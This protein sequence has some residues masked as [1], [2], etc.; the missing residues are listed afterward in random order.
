MNPV[1]IWGNLLSYSVQ[2]LALVAAG[3]ILQ[4]L[5]RVRLPRA[6]LLFCQMMLLVCFLLPAVQPWQSPLIV[7]PEDTAA[8]AVS[9]A[10]QQPVQQQ[11]AQRPTIPWEKTALM[12]LA[13]G[14]ALRALWLLVGL[15]RLSRYRTSATPLYPLPEA[16]EAA[17]IR[18]GAEA[19]V[20]VSS[21]VEGP[22]TF[23]YL[24]PVILLPPA[25]LEKPFETQ[26][27]IASH[28]FLHVRR[29]DWLLT[30]CEELAGA[31]LWFH[32]AV[33]WLLA[34][35][36]LSREQVVDREVVSLTS[37][38]DPY[39]TALLSMAGT[40]LR[41]DLAPAPLFLRKRHLAQRIRALLKEVSMSKQRL[42]SSYVSIA[43][44]LVLAVCTAVVLFPLNGTAQVQVQ[45]VNFND[46]PGVTV[47]PGGK[48]LH[49]PPVRY[50]A[51]AL[52]GRI[53]G[54]VTAVLTL[55]T[56]GTVS[57]ARVVSGPE[58]LRRTVLESALQWHY[59]NE[60]KSPGTAQAVVEFR[61][62]VAPPVQT[63]VIG[64]IIGT[65]PAPAT[66]PPPPPPP[67]PPAGM[68]IS[69]VPRPTGVIGALPFIGSFDVSALPEPLQSMVR[70]K[71]TPFQGQQLSSDLLREINNALSQV[72]SHLASGGIRA[73]T[74]GE[75]A[76]MAIRLTDGTASQA[77]AAPAA[78]ASTANFPSTS[79]VQRIRV[80][81]NVQEARLQEKVVP[82]YPALAR[83]ARISGVVR[84]DVV[85]G[86]D[87]RI[88]NM[89][90]VTGHPLLVPPAQEAVRQWVY[91]PTLLNGQPVE[92]MTQVDVNFT[93]Q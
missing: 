40:R 4:L 5:F 92:V 87:G 2:V 82:A 29:H 14:A 19:V 25:I 32:P 49:R 52:P 24:Y 67:P 43:A 28:E 71:L 56:D 37:A 83:S 90:L 89:Q 46:G 30:I 22:V 75:A 1:Q 76:T 18:T 57:D 55:S 33:W 51:A 47:D 15:A 58:D 69:P 77:P 66:A 81:G 50:P 44:M 8:A 88:N 12:A 48:L 26:F 41:L 62:P 63:G 78:A 60:A 86:T 45:Q 84:F 35:I 91:Q 17:R 34:Q 65:A 20:C 54:I 80:G 31:V 16:I 21:D 23:G 9:A 93:L 79:G 59:L 64:G 27:A 61:I 74:A 10:A 39:V 42:I 72:D 3:A 6:H 73:S 38:R 11:P 85:I 7:V 70:E 13:A 53:E 36:R 68:T